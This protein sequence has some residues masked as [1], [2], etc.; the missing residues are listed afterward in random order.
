MKQREVVWARLALREL[1]DV[2]DHIFRETGFRRTAERYRDRVI[3]AAE[4]IGWAAEG[5][6]LRNDISPGLRM[7]VVE[8]RLIVFYRIVG[9]RVRI[10]RLVDGR[11]DYVRLLK[12]ETP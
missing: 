1:T 10:V 4:R 3:A 8:R 5:G 12:S 11:R 9:E 6:R 7:W 2:I